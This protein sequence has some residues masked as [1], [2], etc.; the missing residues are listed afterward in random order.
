ME[1]FNWVKLTV[2]L[3]ETFL[4]HMRYKYTNDRQSKEGEWSGI[5][6]RRRRYDAVEQGWDRLSGGEGQI[7]IT[8]E[9]LPS[10]K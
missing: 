10:S 9:R 7:T 3:P 4:C 6:I 1:V 5:S 8:T 2:V